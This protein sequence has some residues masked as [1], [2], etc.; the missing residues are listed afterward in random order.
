MLRLP[1]GDAFMERH[2]PLA[3]LAPRD[4][5]AR[6]IDYEMKR[7]GSRARAARHH[8]R[9]RRT[10]CASAFPNIYAECLRFGI[11]I[12]DAADPGRAGGAL[13]VRR[14][15]LGSARPHHAPRA[16]GDRRERVHRAARRQSPGLQLAARGPGVRATA[17]RTSWRAQIDELRAA[18]RA[19]ACPSGRPAR[20]CRATRRS[21]SRHN[22]DELRRTMWNYVGIVRSDARLRRAARRIALL[23]EEIREYYWKHL[24]T[25]D[26]L[27]LRNIATVAQLIIAS[28]AS[29]RESRGL[30]YTIDHAA[31]ARR[32]RRRHRDQARRAAAPARAMSGAARAMTLGAF[33]ARAV[34]WS[35]LLDAGAADRRRSSCWRGCSAAATWRCVGGAVEVLLYAAASFW[36]RARRRHGD[37]AAGVR[38]RPRARAVRAVR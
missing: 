16:V 37:A 8:A 14:R 3:D 6:A 21:W 20:P 29:R 38:A 24:V 34:A 31:D 10:S 4:V 15:D 23:E 30:H 26:L 5:V 19:R 7:T 9:A 13:H 1:D 27:E 11:D 28:A 35:A 36:L 33:V 25:R 22:W 17:P 12:T 2:H 18:P 32:L